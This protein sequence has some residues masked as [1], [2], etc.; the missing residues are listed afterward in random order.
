MAILLV[1]TGTTSLPACLAW[2]LAYNDNRRD[3]LLRRQC[4]NVVG[5]RGNKRLDNTRRTRNIP[6]R[7]FDKICLDGKE[8]AIRDLDLRKRT[9]CSII[10]YKTPSGEYIVNPEPDLMLQ[11]GSKLILIGRPPQI[12]L[13]KDVYKV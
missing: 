2:Y 6:F 9:G 4:P 5:H 8:L 7:D 3:T 12:E 13:L 11:H 1:G 10:G